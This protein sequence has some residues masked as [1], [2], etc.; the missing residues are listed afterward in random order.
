MARLLH[1]YQRAGREPLD[2]RLF[3]LGVILALYHDCGYIR[4]RNDSRHANGAN[5]RSPMYRAAR[6]I[7]A[8]ICH[9]SGWRI[10]RRWRR[11]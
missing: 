3:T 10:S 9:R 2:A 5:I 4:H 11:V 6:A 7:C 1:G 8:A